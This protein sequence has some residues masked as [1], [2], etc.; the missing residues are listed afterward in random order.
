MPPNMTDETEIE[1]IDTSLTVRRTFD[2]P[3]ER[4]FEAFTD[5]RQVDR[6]WGPD[7]FTTTT[8]EMDVTP[9]QHLQDGMTFHMVTQ[10]ARQPS[11]PICRYH[12]FPS[13]LCCDRRV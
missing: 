10:S 5:P 4:V 8:E 7:G 3:R 1:T 9:G 12:D 13:R 6:W 2:A 11:F